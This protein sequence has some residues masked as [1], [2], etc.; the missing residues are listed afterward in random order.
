MKTRRLNKVLAYFSYVA[1]LKYCIYCPLAP[2]LHRECTDS[3]NDSFQLGGV[4]TSWRAL[5]IETL[6]MCG[7]GQYSIRLC[8]GELDTILSASAH[9][10]IECYTTSDCLLCAVRTPF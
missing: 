4:L 2:S 10:P 7:C 8:S 1:L 9:C 6:L 3:L 5:T